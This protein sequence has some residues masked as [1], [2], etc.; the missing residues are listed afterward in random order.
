MATKPIPFGQGFI[1][2]APT[3]AQHEQPAHGQT[4]DSEL[5]ITIWR[6][7]LVLYVGTAAQ[8]TDEGLIPNGFE[9]P[10]AAGDRH[11]GAGG[12]R[13]WLC[14]RRPEGH[15]GPMR[16]WLELDSW[17]VRV[18]V[19]GRDQRWHE[20]RNIERKENELKA[21]KHRLTSAGMAEWDAHWHR[22]NAAI[23]DKA[24]QAFKAKVPALNPPRRTRKPKTQAADRPGQ[25]A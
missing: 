17:C 19:V 4:M 13:Y 10:R 8:L 18:S 14:R 7:S 23:S 20:R 25:S 1:A 15:K 2:P 3:Q 12:L 22:L 21:A 11:W 9:W 24:F 6:D 16:S 5:C